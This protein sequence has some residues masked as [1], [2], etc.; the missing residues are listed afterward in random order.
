MI[1]LKY[2]I[3]FLSVNIVVNA[4]SVEETFFWTSKVFSLLHEAFDLY[5][6]FKGDVI[7]TSN[8]EKKLYASLANITN[9]IESVEHDIPQVTIAKMKEL[10]RDFS[11]IIHF[12]IKLDD[13]I[14]HINNIESKYE[15]F[16]SKWK[17][18]FEYILRL[19]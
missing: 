3:A 8:K 1:R 6:E 19:F 13:L 12:E 18:T 10:E 17:K 9:L 11:E 14:N 7:S 15:K 2:L 4:I 5:E 16:V